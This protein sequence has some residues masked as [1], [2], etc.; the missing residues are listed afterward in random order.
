[1]TDLLRTS[2]AWLAGKFNQ[3]A[4]TDGLYRLPD[5]TELVFPMTMGTSEATRTGTDGLV[6]ESIITDVTFTTAYLAVGGNLVEPS[7]GDEIE[8]DLGGTI[9]NLEV[10]SPGGDAPAWRYSDPFKTRIRAHVTEIGDL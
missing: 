9:R 1:M 8:I 2:T 4:A 10:S 5:G 6:V 7:P 3:H